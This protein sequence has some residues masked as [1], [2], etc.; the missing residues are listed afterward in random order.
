MGTDVED[1]YEALFNVEMDLDNDQV[2]LFSDEEDD[3]VGLRSWISREEGSGNDVHSPTTPTTPAVRTHTVQTTIRHRAKPSSNPRSPYGSPRPRP[4]VVSMLPSLTEPA[5]AGAPEV[6]SLQG[7]SPLGRLFTGR[8]TD[9][10]DSAASAERIERI[11][12]GVHRVQEL[13]DDVR[14]LPV[15]RLKDEMKQLQERQATIEGLLMML[16]RGMRNEVGHHR[17]R[18]GTL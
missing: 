6:P 15:A 4:R 11:E 16:T 7:S 13:L 18:Q 10:P 1:I 2:R 17:P 14:G 12:D 9:L 5:R 3:H 8:F